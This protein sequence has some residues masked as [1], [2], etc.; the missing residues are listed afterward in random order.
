M[1]STF[2]IIFYLFMSLTFYILE[3]ASIARKHARNVP[4]VAIARWTHHL[5]RFSDLASAYCARHHALKFYSGIKKPVENG[6]GF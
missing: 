6:C 4:A 3:I 2:M 1:P 5:M